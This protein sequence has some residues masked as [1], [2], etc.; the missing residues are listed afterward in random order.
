MFHFRDILLA[1]LLWSLSLAV[2]AGSGTDAAPE[3]TRLRVL[4]V[5]NSHTYTND[6][7]G[8]V[9]GLA[10]MRG[11]DLQTGMVA[12]PGHSLADHLAQPRLRE[13]LQGEWDWVVLQQGP[14][15]TARGRAQLIRSVEAISAELGTRPARIALMSIW[16]AKADRASTLAAE[17][18]YRLGA[19]AVD[20]CVLP[21]ATA[22]RH[23]LAAGDAPRLYRHDRLHA[24]AAG[25]LLAAL[26]VVPGLLGDPA[27]GEG[28][29]VAPAPAGPSGELHRLQASALRAHREEPRR[30]DGLAGD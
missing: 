16:P 14:S 12:E 19:I 27:P 28:G 2:Q 22:W 18:N 24:T 8:M 5:G 23:A 11:V 4:F 6:L 21:V 10:A 20:A 13:A 3:A 26:T 30:C 1:C 9:A 29:A 17:E 7:P 15:S 25:T